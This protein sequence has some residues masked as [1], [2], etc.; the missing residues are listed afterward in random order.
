MPGVKGSSEGGSYYYQNY[1]ATIGTPNL[2]TWYITY[3]S[4]RGVYIIMTDF[5]YQASAVHSKL[6]RGGSTWYLDFCVQQGGG[7]FFLCD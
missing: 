4:W 2:N 3:P 7:E 5:D 1:K 6:V